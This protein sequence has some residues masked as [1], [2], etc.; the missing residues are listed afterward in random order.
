MVEVNW[1]ASPCTGDGGVV[2]V[3][4]RVVGHQHVLRF[5]FGFGFGMKG[6]GGGGRWPAMDK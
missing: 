3:G 6:E 1:V 4:R 2:W 5:G